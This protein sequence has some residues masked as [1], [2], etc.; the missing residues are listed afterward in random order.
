MA[1]GR[2]EPLWVGAVAVGW[3]EAFAAGLAWAGHLAVT[4]TARIRTGA[5]AVVAAACILFSRERLPTL[6]TVGA[7]RRAPRRSGTRKTRF[8]AARSTARRALEPILPTHAACYAGSAETPSSRQVSADDRGSSV[9]SASRLAV[10][11]GI[12]RP[13]FSSGFGATLS[14]WRGWGSYMYL[15]KAF[16]A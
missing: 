16:V 3:H 9:S 11:L 14:R 5:T 1:R 10:V 12:A 15:G 4:A 13:L 6:L 8:A 7:R 2:A